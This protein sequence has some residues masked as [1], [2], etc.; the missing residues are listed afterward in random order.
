MAEHM[1]ED[2]QPSDS[3]TLTPSAPIDQ[4]PRPTHRIKGMK[5]GNSGVQLLVST[6]NQ[7]YDAENIE[8]GDSAWQSVGNWEGESL[9]KVVDTLQQRQPSASSPKTA[10]NDNSKLENLGPGQRL[11]RLAAK[12]DRNTFYCLSVL[13][14]INHSKDQNAAI[15]QN[16]L[17]WCAFGPS[18]SSELGLA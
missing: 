12:V 17:M 10:A 5:V 16:T 6:G 18:F 7:L 2:V 13:F 8:G 14:R 9:L 3:S 11:L 4:P 15:A 1:E